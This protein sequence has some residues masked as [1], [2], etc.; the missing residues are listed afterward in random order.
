MIKLRLHMIDVKVYTI[1]K[2]LKYALIFNFFRYIAMEIA[3][4][5]KIRQ[6]LRLNQ[7]NSSDIDI[8]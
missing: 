5:F 1:S 4:V 6:E 3:K 2:K 7:W 8:Q